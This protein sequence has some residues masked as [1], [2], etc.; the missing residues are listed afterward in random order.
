MLMGNI[1]K[2]V[3]GKWFD[4]TTGLFTL[5]L[6]KKVAERSHGGPLGPIRLQ[7]WKLKY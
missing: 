2:Q 7:E 4:N 6:E 1:Q 5:E 3:K